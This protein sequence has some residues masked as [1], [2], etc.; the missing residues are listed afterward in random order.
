MAS[1]P[2]FD[3]DLLS[4]LLKKRLSERPKSRWNL[5]K[6]LPALE[7]RKLDLVD[8]Q[9]CALL[10]QNGGGGFQSLEPLDPFTLTEARGAQRGFRLKK[11]QIGSCAIQTTDNPFAC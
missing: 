7:R 10:D 5:D 8:D 11:V 3:R 6:D 9:R 4:E 1:P 2:A